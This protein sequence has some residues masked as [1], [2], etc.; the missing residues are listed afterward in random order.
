MN[1]INICDTTTL[2]K[3]KEGEPV[4]LATLSSVEVR[5]PLIISGLLVANRMVEMKFAD[6]YRFRTEQDALNW[7][8]N[9]GKKSVDDEL[10]KLGAKYDR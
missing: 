2:I 8:D 5:E 10:M 6:A 9:I 3:A 7:L 1:I 4:V